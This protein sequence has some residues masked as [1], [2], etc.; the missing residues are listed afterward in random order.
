MSIIC[1]L[2][3]LVQA[4]FVGQPWDNRVAPDE[5]NLC[6]NM[7]PLLKVERKTL[8]EAYMAELKPILTH[9]REVLCAGSEPDYTVLMA[10]LAHVVQDP[11]EKTGWCPV[12]ISN[13]GTGKVN[14][15]GD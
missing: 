4:K 3:C 7:M 8:S 2:L 1:S 10:W 13:Q 5:Y 15:F 12:I 14:S 9:I 6:A 11:A